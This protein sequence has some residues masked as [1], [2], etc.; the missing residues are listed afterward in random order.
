MAM[1]PYMAGGY[2]IDRLMGGDGKVGLAV[3]TGVGGFGTG[4]FSGALG[5][6]AATAGMTNT[7]ASNAAANSFPTI[8]G[9]MPTAGAGVGTGIGGAGMTT[10]GANTPMG[11]SNATQFGSVNP[12][13]TGGF[14][15]SISPFTPLGGAGVGGNVGFLGQPISNQVMDSALTGEKGLLG[16]GL[17]NTFIQDGFDFINE[18][19]ED[20]SLNDKLSMGMLG[21]QAIDTVTAPPPQLQVAPPQ[22]IP[23]KEPTIGAPLA[24]NVQAPNTSFYKDP[25]KLYE[26]TMYG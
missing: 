24:I 2:A 17:E 3:G 8:L 22:S 19:Y 23:A 26:E 1:I 9:S 20:M 4:T 10:I 6:E 11:L 13:T 12:L 5:S 14:S 16:Y 18:G 25:R 15:E 7:V 21:G